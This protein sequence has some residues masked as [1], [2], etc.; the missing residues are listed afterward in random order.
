MPG[1]ASA[2]RIL[3]AFL[4]SVSLLDNFSRSDKPGTTWKFQK[5]AHNGDLA[6]NDLVR[7]LNSCVRWRTQMNGLVPRLTT[8]KKLSVDLNISQRKLWSMVASRE[9]PVVRFG[10]AVRIDQQD[11]EKW[12]SLNKRRCASHGR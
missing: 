10:R 3:V 6:R 12:L 7:C 8:V 2:K 9:L 1:Q 11:L 5:A 4:S